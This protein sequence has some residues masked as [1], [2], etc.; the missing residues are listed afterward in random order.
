MRKQRVRASIELKE[1]VLLEL[2]KAGSNIQLL[3]EQH[4]LSIKTIRRWKADY[5]K[6][7]MVREKDSPHQNNQINQNNRF[8]ELTSIPII[9]QISE[10]KK[11]DLV[12]DN[13]SCSI[14]GKISS[15]QLLKLV[16][17]LESGL[18]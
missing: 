13:Y 4:N 7:K 16:Q 8:I 5:Y 6:Q 14:V 17:L 18:C 11:V 1:Q 9:N 15:N 2:L 3:A 12:F 10:L